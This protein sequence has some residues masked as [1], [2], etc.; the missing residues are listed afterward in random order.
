M[1]IKFDETN[2]PFFRQGEGYNL[3]HRSLVRGVLDREIRR[4]IAPDN[5]GWLVIVEKEKVE[6]LMHGSDIEVQTEDKGLW[7]PRDTCPSGVLDPS[8]EA[9]PYTTP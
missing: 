1:S 9:F 3:L 6:V 8:I 5:S 4:E 7:S 2:V